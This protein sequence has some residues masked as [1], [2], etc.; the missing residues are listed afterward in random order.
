L[1]RFGILWKFEIHKSCIINH[2][3]LFVW[4]QDA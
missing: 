1:L 3:C 2:S 4:I